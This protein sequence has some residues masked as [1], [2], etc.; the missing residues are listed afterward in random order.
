MFID[1]ELKKKKT[2]QGAERVPAYLLTNRRDKFKSI[3][4]FL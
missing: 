1:A 4:T 2:C 3:V